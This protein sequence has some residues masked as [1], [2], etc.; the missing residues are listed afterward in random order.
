MSTETSSMKKPTPEAYRLLMQG[1]LALS[2]IEH[3]GMKL[4][5][6]YLGR[7]IAK[8]EGDIRELTA[9]L[10]ADPLWA[11][12]WSRLRFGKK[13]NNPPNLDSTE[14]LA[15]VLYD[16]LGYEGRRKTDKGRQKVD[17]E[18]LSE[19]DLPFVKGYLKHKK[20]QKVPTPTWSSSTPSWCGPSAAAS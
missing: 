15:W 13:K 14:Q 5:L 17:E 12:T 4:D 9:K 16:E 3:N 18:A 10:K 11:R 19:I 6:D 20:L 1:S 2:R 7:A 8:V